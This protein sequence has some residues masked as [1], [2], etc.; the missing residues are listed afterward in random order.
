MIQHSGGEVLGAFRACDVIQCHD[1][2]RIVT[3]PAMVSLEQRL[4]AHSS[5]CTHVV[6]SRSTRGLRCDGRT[7]CDLPPG[8][9]VRDDLHAARWEKVQ[10]R[11]YFRG[12]GVD[13]SRDCVKRDE[14]IAAP[15][16]YAISGVVLQ[17]GGV[18]HNSCR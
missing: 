13:L 17:L 11:V 1:N 4:F 18:D 12:F 9:Q 3:F 10:M 15:V 7:S 5:T 16:L 6:I 14:V 2:V 8:M